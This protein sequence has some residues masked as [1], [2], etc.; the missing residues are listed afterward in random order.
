MQRL[1]YKSYDLSEGWYKQ[2]E[3]R[4]FVM[5]NSE[6]LNVFCSRDLIEDIFKEHHTGSTRIRAIS[7][8]LT[9]IYFRRAMA[10]G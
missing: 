10:N 3:L 5:D 8:F 1:K 7:F 2:E 4:S 9:M 6:L